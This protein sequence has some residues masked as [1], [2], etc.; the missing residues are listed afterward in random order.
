MSNNIG[1]NYTELPKETAKTKSIGLVWETKESLFVGYNFYPTKGH[2]EE[3][4]HAET[5]G[6]AVEVIVNPEPMSKAEKLKLWN[7]GTCGISLN[8]FNWV[9][10]IYE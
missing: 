1:N 8:E 9:I 7:S 3:Q 5:L 4:N 6:K 2:A 10:E